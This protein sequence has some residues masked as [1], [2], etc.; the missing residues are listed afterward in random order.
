MGTVLSSFLLPQRQCLYRHLPSPAPPGPPNPPAYV[1]NLSEQ[2]NTE[3][4]E[5]ILKRAEATSLS[6]T[7]SCIWKSC[8]FLTCQSPAGGRGWPSMA[9]RGPRLPAN[10]DWRTFYL[11]SLLIFWLFWWLLWRGR[12]WGNGKSQ[13]EERLLNHLVCIHPV[14]HYSRHLLFCSHLSVS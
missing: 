4:D 8:L 2:L 3:D 5:L 10:R 1:A 6:L 11:T 13:E 14:I 12:C 9:P 7:P